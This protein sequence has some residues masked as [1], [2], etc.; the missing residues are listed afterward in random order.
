MSLRNQG[1]TPESPSILKRRLDGPGVGLE[2]QMSFLKVS[3]VERSNVLETLLNGKKAEYGYKRFCGGWK[4]G[5]GQE[6]KI[7]VLKETFLRE[8]PSS[9]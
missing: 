1:S 8:R 6:E 3:Q 9:P 4:P 2:N 7:R 5:Q